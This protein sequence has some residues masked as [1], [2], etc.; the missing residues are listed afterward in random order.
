VERSGERS[1][2]EWSEVERGAKWSGAVSKSA[3]YIYLRS[4]LTA[5]VPPPSDGAE[6]S[7]EWSGSGVERSGAER[8]G[9][10]RS[11]AERGVERSGAKWSG[12]ERSGAKW[13][14]VERSGAER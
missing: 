5:G 3:V 6:R 12:V 14:G 10:E 4:I 7:G 9:A 2:A 1:G 8:S 13:S 11:G